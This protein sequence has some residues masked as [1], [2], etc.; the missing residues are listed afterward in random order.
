M[1]YF[2]CRAVSY[3][4]SRRPLRGGVDRNLLSKPW[5]MRLFGLKPMSPAQQRAWIEGMAIAKLN[6]WAA[7]FIAKMGADRLPA[8]D[9]WRAPKVPL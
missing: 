3:R 7:D 4:G 2:F 6:E 9:G 1:H 5:F 8:D